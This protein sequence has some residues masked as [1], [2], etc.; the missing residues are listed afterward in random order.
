MKRL[1][2][3]VA[4]LLAVP[5]AACGPTPG[6]AFTD[7]TFYWQFRDL[8]GNVFGN[9]ATGASGCGVVN[10]DHLRFR[11]QGP[12]GPFTM[13]VPCT[14]VNGV[15]GA[16]FVG[17]PAGA[18]GWV[19]D[20]LRI[21]FPVFTVSGSGNVIDFP[22]FDLELLAVYPNM[23]LFYQLPAGVNCTGISEI[24]FQLFNLD[25]GVTEYSSQNALVACGSPFGFTMPSIPVGNYAVPYMEAVAPLGTPLYKACRIGLPPQEPLVQQLPNGNAYTIG[26]FPAGG[27]GCP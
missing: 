26:L 7:V 17:V 27:T 8:D 18:Y 1:A 12:A 2:V 25:G 14:A 13:T 15:A 3:L 20:G 6:P 16:Q 5:L 19:V 22:T 21:G 10:V 4:T 11:F 23:D 24:L 9:A